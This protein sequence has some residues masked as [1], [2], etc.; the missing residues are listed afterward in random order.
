MRGRFHGCLHMVAV[1]VTA[2]DDVPMEPQKRNMSTMYIKELLKTANTMP[3]LPP[4]SEDVLH[5]VQE[6]RQISDVDINEEADLRREFIRC[7]DMVAMAYK[8]PETTMVR[9]SAEL[10]NNMDRIYAK[11][12]FEETV[13]K[14]FEEITISIPIGYKY[15]LGEE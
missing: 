7:A 6:W 15:I 14:P 2:I 4:Y 9:V 3:S 11:S 12:W 8:E 1:C 5:V 10:Q 13:E